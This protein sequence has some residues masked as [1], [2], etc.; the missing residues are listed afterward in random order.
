MTHTLHRQGSAES[1]QNDY[2]VLA[3]VARQF[4]L[5]TDESKASAMKRLQGICDTMAANEPANLGSLYV[6]NGTYAHD[7]SAEEIRARLKPNGFV[8]CVYDDRERLKQVLADL[9]EKDFGISITVSGLIDEVFDTCGEIGLQPH[10]ISYSL[11]AWGKK[12]LLP[13]AEILEITSMCGQGRMSY[14]LRRLRLHGLIERISNIH[15]YRLTEEGLRV[16]LFF[17]RVHLRILRLGLA[18]ILSETPSG[19]ASLRQSF[20]RLAAAIDRSVEKAK[21]AA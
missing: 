2:C 12:K 19:D 21:F 1:L 5:K 13:K 6:L 8:L 20:D 18:P 15:R 10:T 9:K 11:G 7:M 4:D 17:N 14:D 16:T 3:L